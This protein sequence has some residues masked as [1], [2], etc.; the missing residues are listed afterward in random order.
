MGLNIVL[1]ENKT[2]VQFLLR[3]LIITDLFGGSDVLSVSYMYR[4]EGEA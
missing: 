4:S 1:V 2:I 3:N